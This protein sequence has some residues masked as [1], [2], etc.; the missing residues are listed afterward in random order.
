MNE[1]LNAITS[2]FPIITI[3]S[4]NSIYYNLSIFCFSIIAT[5]NHI[6]PENLD[7]L[8]YPVKML[9]SNILFSL[10]NINPLIGVLISIIDLFPLFTNKK[11]FKELGEKFL[12]IPR[13]AIEIYLIYLLF[14]NYKLDCFI[15]ISCK[16]L[17]YFE[18][19]YRI[20]RNNRNNFTVFHSAEHLGLLLLFKDLTK[21]DFDYKLLL[22]LLLSS[23]FGIALILYSIGYYLNSNFLKRTPEY[24]KENTT[25]ITL[26][27][28]KFKS[29]ENIN[30]INLFMKPWS[31]IYKIDFITWKRLEYMCN[32]M[33]S[34]VEDF[35]IVVS[36]Y[37]EGSFVAAYIAKKLVKQH[38]IIN[39]LSDCTGK[40]IL[41]VEFISDN[42]QQLRDIKK[43]LLEKHSQS[44]KTFCLFSKGDSQPD[45]NYSNNRIPTI[46]EWGI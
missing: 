36:S 18:R 8:T 11:L 9:F 25:L 2:L 41:Y 3:D 29:N 26:L 12:Q 20:K 42:E 16:I 19:R 17:Y 15:M 38:I 43:L 22:N 33:L 14:P 27:S 7:G 46:W 28:E 44:V 30:L 24:I 21:I 45:Y 32:S 31:P 5:I 4:K 34:K 40:R 39:S 10:I 1:M 35:D 37:S 6:F 23:F 13:Q